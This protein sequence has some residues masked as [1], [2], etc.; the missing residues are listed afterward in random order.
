MST[1]ALPITIRPAYADDELS[2][3]RLAVLDSAEAPPTRPLLLAEIDGE[4]RVALSLRNGSVIADPFFA[5]TG[6]IALLRAHAA[7]ASPRTWRPRPR[8]ERSP[9]PIWKRR[10][11]AGRLA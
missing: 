5:T 3:A 4:L 2:L 10:S 11:G 7:G 1:A 9:E 6:L 8:P